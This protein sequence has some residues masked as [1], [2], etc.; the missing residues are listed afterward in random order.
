[1][2]VHSTPSSVVVRLTWGQTEKRPMCSSRRWR[3][4][5]LEGGRVSTVT[6]QCGRERE[7]RRL[8]TEKSPV[9]FIFSNELYGLPLSPLSLD[10]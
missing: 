8:R 1:M 10:I 4:E 9:K 5:R 6:S 3:G 2:E 7:R